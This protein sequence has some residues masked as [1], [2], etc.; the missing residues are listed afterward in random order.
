MSLSNNGTQLVF[1]AHF[2]HI[3]APEILLRTPYDEQSDMWSVG[4]I[5]YLLLSGTLPFVGRSQ[6]ELFRAIVKGDYD[7]DEASWSGVSADA[8]DLVKSLLV[9]D[10]SKRLTAK[11]ALRSDWLMQNADN[12][13]MNDLMNASNRLRTFNARMKL[14]S[15]MIAINWV[16]KTTVWKAQIAKKEAEKKAQMDQSVANVGAKMSNTGI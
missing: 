6:R 13:K 15:A 9:T 2:K 8:M 11:Q 1:L 7:M 14:R 10:P 4:V 5:I 12:L 16:S 3:S